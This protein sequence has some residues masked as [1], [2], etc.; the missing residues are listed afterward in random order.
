MT[1]NELSFE[2]RRAEEALAF[3]DD[4]GSITVSAATYDENGHQH[5][6]KRKLSRAEIGKAVSSVLSRRIDALRDEFHKKKRQ[7]E[8]LG[9]VK[10]AGLAI[11]PE[12]AEVQCFQAN[13]FD[14]YG[15]I[16]MDL[17]EECLDSQTKLYFAR[18]PGSDLWVEFDDLPDETREALLKLAKGKQ[19][20]EVEANKN[21]PSWMIAG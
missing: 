8:Y 14:P 7:D 3:F 13:Y 21:G 18:S 1:T 4:A 19:Q 6:M 5:K 20:L 15:I 10:Q 11:N 9:L 16:G 2:I 17:P 12:T